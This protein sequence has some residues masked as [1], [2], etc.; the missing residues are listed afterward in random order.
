MPVHHDKSI[1]GKLASLR[2][3]VSDDDV[4]KM[5]QELLALE[6]VDGSVEA[7]VALKQGTRKE[8]KWVKAEKKSSEKA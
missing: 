2:E 8:K 3:S 6:D 1:Y 5:A 7:E 4:A